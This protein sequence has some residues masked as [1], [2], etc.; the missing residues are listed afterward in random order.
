MRSG[1]RGRSPRGLPS[2]LPP[3]PAGLAPAGRPKR[4]ACEASDRSGNLARASFWINATRQ[5]GGIGGGGI[6]GGDPAT[7]ALP[8]SNPS[9]AVPYNGTATVRAAAN[10]TVGPAAIRLSSIGANGTEADG[11]APAFARVQ[12]VRAGDNY[13]QSGKDLYSRTAIG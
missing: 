1:C 5:G 8:L 4:A 6:G 2:P 3:A 10:S 12:H 7:H 13:T 9:V 11:P